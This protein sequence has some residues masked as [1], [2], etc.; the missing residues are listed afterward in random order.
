M[1][2]VVV[3]QNSSKHRSL[4]LLWAIDH[5]GESGPL[6]TKGTC[7][8]WR[9]TPLEIHL[10]DLWSVHADSAEAQIVEGRN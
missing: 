8:G 7:G 2:R 9:F 10:D 3:V 4:K 1:I 5:K 6:I